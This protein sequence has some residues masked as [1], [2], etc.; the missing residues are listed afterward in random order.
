MCSQVRFVSDLS[1]HPDL[2]SLGDDELYD[3]PLHASSLAQE[4]LEDSLGFCRTFRLI[5][6][7]ASSGSRCQKTLILEAGG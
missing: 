5:G 1:A 2:A 6:G 3:E 7:Q 4:G